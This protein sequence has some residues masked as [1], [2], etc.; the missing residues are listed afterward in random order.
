[1]LRQEWLSE[2]SH[3]KRLKEEVIIGEDINGKIT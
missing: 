3:G 1:M 2:V